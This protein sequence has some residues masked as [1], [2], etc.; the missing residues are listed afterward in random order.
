MTRELQRLRRGPAKVRKIQSSG[1]KMSEASFQ[2]PGT[3]RSMASRFC[4]FKDCKKHAS[5]KNVDDDR[6]ASPRIVRIPFNFLNRKSC[7]THKLPGWTTIRKKSKMCH[8]A[9]CLKYGSFRA[10]RQYSCFEHKTAEFIR[11]QAIPSQRKKVATVATTPQTAKKGGAAVADAAT[12][13]SHQKKADSDD[14]FEWDSGGY[15]AQVNNAARRREHDDCVQPL[16]RA[17]AN[18]FFYKRST[19]IICHSQLYFRSLPTSQHNS[20]IL[21]GDMMCCALTSLFL[22]LNGLSK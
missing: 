2:R 5:Y 13:P 1:Q 6:C 10:G 20:Q 3:S 19:K 12:K 16:K 21:F 7:A 11:L 4:Y 17:T 22:Y 18:K 14:D 9:G 8:F 15:S